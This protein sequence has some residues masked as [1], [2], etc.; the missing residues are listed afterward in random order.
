MYNTAAGQYTQR[1]NRIG[2]QAGSKDASRRA[3]QRSRSG[4]YREQERAASERASPPLSPARMC[5]SHRESHNGPINRVM[6]GG[7]LY[8]IIDAVGRTLRRAPRRPLPCA[9]VPGLVRWGARIASQPAFAG[10][11]T[12][13]GYRWSAALPG[14]HCHS[15]RQSPPTLSSV[16]CCFRGELTR[17]AAICI[18]TFLRGAF[19]SLS[20]SPQRCLFFFFSVLVFLFAAGCSV[21]V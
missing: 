14:A 12:E 6:R 3:K 10:R 1:S 9:R 19:D 7:R 2:R 17:P 4:S 21:R 16:S 13:K 18:L 15:G 20:R 11:G 5:V 8:R